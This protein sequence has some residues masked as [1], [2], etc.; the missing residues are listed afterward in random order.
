MCA[1]QRFP[2]WR[3]PG[4]NPGS[5]PDH[6]LVT[7]LLAAVEQQEQAGRPR[8]VARWEDEEN[9]VG[10]TLLNRH[11]V[12]FLEQSVAIAFGGQRRS[13]T[14][15]PGPRG[16]NRGQRAKAGR[17]LTEEK[18]RGREALLTAW[19]A[20]ALARIVDEVYLSAHGRPGEEKE[21]RIRVVARAYDPQR[22]C[23]GRLLSYDF[24]LR[25]LTWLDTRYPD[26]NLPYFTNQRAI[27]RELSKQTD[28]LH[29]ETL[30]APARAQVVDGI[31]L[32]N[33]IQTAPDDVRVGIALYSTPFF[34]FDDTMI[35]Q[36]VALPP[37]GR[38]VEYAQV[39]RALHRLR[40]EKRS[41]DD[42]DDAEMRK[43]AYQVEVYLWQLEKPERRLVWPKEAQRVLPD[44]VR[45]TER[46]LAQAQEELDRQKEEE[47]N[48]AGQALVR[49]RDVEQH[50]DVAPEEAAT[51]RKV[52]QEWLEHQGFNA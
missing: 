1:Q 2:A 36:R 48:L 37:H 4:D 28:N 15:G 11:Q 38:I 33:A 10:R 26:A 25:T 19:R 27:E 21:P 42:A 52:V 46:R 7:Q 31:S 40:S 22:G 30:A 23:I 13:P 9:S 44:R 49:D 41:A 8:D 6:Q 16:Q 14:T 17:G 12:P 18:W 51:L 39:L 45:R 35:P 32:L 3:C 20:K 24:L 50:L 5:T 43:V 29:A 47:A 34:D